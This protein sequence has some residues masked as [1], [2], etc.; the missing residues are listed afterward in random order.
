MN[1]AERRLIAYTTIA[2]AL[3]HSI[4][5]TFA[6]L[7][8]RIQMDL[9][10]SDALMGV[11][12]SV[13]GWTF[14]TAAIPAGFLSDRLG[15][16]RVLYYTFVS[17]AA[18][19]VLVGLSPNRW[20]LVGA[21][22]F[23]GMCIG[24]YHPA[25]ISL[26]AQE[27]R[28]RG[29]ALGYHGVSGNIGIA[30]TPLVAGAIATAFDNWRAAYFLM[31]A[32]AAAVTLMLRA[33]RLPLHEQQEVV[34]V[35]GEAMPATLAGGRERPRAFLFPLALVYLAF[36][37][38]GLIYRGAITFLPKHI[39]DEVSTSLGDALTTVALLTGAV[40]QYVGGLLSQ[41]LRLEGLAAL[42]VL[43]VV[44]S[45]FLTGFLSGGPLVVFAAT[46]IFFNFA[47]QPVFSSLI[48]EYTPVG[49]LGRSF[50]VS[51]FATFGLGAAG[52][53][54]AGIF[55]DRWDTGAAFLAMAAFAA[56]TF[57]L[58]LALLALS[59]RRPLP[60]VA[61]EEARPSL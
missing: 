11:I 21:L 51:F 44:P 39:H 31:A 10:T 6:A 23:L 43:L 12:A 48:A 35:E 2:H 38:T 28:Q 61:E 18:G 8:V 34:Q 60:A 40:G 41:R 37:L 14:G 22:A 29:L 30:L 33:W 3:I 55:V 47:A 27:I 45:L 52:G 5:V 13:F 25:G 19:A 20:F 49:L 32:L 58:T 26:I 16:R 24:L 17:A 50:G 54:I 53:A 56:V 59:L 1:L 9:G 42:S 46:F 57:I 36:V 15:S 4:E 7:L